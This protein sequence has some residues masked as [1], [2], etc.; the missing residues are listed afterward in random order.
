MDEFHLLDRML[1]Q[2]FLTN[3]INS[4]L[5]CWSKECRSV[6]ELLSDP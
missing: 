1:V 5:Y 4:S 3:G 2:Y 6:A